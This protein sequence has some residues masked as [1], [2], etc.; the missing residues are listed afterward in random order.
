MID[1]LKDARDKVSILSTKLAAEGI[2]SENLLVPAQKIDLQLISKD[3]FQFTKNQLEITQGEKIQM[4]IEYCEKLQTLY[5]NL[6]KIESELEA[7]GKSPDLIDEIIYHR[8]Q[9]TCL[10]SK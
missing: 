6:P 3:K 7:A 5:K 4:E 2:K 1:R 8:F 10:G 9:T